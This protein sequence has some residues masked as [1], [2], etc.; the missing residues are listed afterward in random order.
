MTSRRQKLQ[1][2]RKR[3]SRAQQLL[4]RDTGLRAS[5]LTL[6]ER[7]PTTGLNNAIDDRGDRVQVRSIGANSGGSRTLPAIVVNDGVGIFAN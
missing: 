5:V 2:L 4:V 1:Q 7:D 3:Q 6:G